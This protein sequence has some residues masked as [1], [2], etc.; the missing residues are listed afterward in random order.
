MLPHHLMHTKPHHHKLM[1]R[2]RNKNRHHILHLLMSWKGKRH[3]A[4]HTGRALW[5]QKTL[6]NLYVTQ[7]ETTA[8]KEFLCWHQCKPCPHTHMI[9][10]GS[11]LALTQSCPL[12][13]EQ[14]FEIILF[15]GP[16]GLKSIQLPS[17]YN[18][19]RYTLNNGLVFCVN[20]QQ[21]SVPQGFWQAGVTLQC[22]Q[23]SICLC[24]RVTRC[25]FSPDQKSSATYRTN[26]C[27]CVK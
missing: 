6:W 25:L 16:T 10:R 26:G 9:S 12:H 20:C 23:C 2:L 8:A 17:S 11:I 1:E 14:L 18:N 7:G 4:I 24:K 19:H 22:R 15:V 21:M 13:E 5:C 27:V 3:S